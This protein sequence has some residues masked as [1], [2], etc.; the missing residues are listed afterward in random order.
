MASMKR[1]DTDSKVS[2]LSVDPTALAPTSPE[3]KKGRKGKKGKVGRKAMGRERS[4]IWVTLLV[5]ITLLLVIAGLVVGGVYAYRAVREMYA[6]V[7]ETRQVVFAVEMKGVDPD[8][9]KYDQNGRPVIVNRP[10]WSSDQTDADVLGTVTDVQTL[11]VP[12]ENGENTLTL[13]LTVEANAHYREGKGYRM[14]STMLL[15]G[16][17]GTFMTYGLVAEGTVI[18]MHEKQDK[19]AAQGKTTSSRADGGDSVAVDPPAQR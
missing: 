9:V 2:S 19:T 5:D 14:G 13:R 8:M 16:M 12:G 15:A 1:H 6:P 18:S 17:K 10:L 7:W 11:L 3:G 4:R